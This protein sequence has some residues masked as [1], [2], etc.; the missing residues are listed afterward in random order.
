[1][2]TLLSNAGPAVSREVL[3]VTCSALKSRYL[4]PNSNAALG[5]GEGGQGR[6]HANGDSDL[7][8]YLWAMAEV[9]AYM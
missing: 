5:W 3:A 6:G 1:M 4:V 2:P 9:E 8:S 7:L